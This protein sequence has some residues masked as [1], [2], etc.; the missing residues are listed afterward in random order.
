MNGSHRLSRLSTRVIS[1][2]GGPVRRRLAQYSL[3]LPTIAAWESK[4]E[5]ESDEQLAQRSRAL[6]YRIQCD[7]PLMQC[8]PE[9]FA[10]VREAARRTIGLR[11]FDTQLLGGMALVNRAIAEMETGEGKTLTAAFPL[12]LHA[13]R[14]RGALLATVN[15][16]L[17]QRDAEWMRPLYELL[18]LSVG[19]VVA[20]IPPEQRRAAYACDI[21][22]GTAREFGFDFL[23]DRLALRSRADSHTTG[24]LDESNSSASSSG[25]VVQRDPHFA[26][27][28]EADSVLIDEARTP[29]IISTL[30]GPADIE[31]TACYR[32]CA[33][34]ASRF[35]DGRHYDRNPEDRSVV[36]TPAGRELVRALDIPAELRALSMLEIYQALE[37][38]IRVNC[39][40][41]RDRHY[42]VRDG[43]ILIVDEFTGRI[44]EGRKWRGGVHQ[45]IEAKEGVSLTPEA[46]PA[47]RVTVQD[48]FL[49][50]PR[51]AGMTGTAKSSARELWSIYR[52]RVLPIPTHKPSARI[53]LPP[54]VYAT[55][56]AKWE[57]IVEEIKQM[58]DRGRP[59]LIGTRSIEASEQLSCCLT[60]AEIS[61]HVLNAKQ[62]AREAEIVAQ[63][64]QP[65]K[66]TVAT[67]MAGRGT[68][69]R[70]GQGVA[71]AGGLHVIGTEM[72]DSARIDRQLAGRC[73]RQGDPGSFRQFLALD[74][75]ILQSALDPAGGKRLAA[76]GC[77][78]DKSKKLLRHFRMAQR[79]IERRQYRERALLLRYE[80]QRK[81]MQREMGQDPYLDIPT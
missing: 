10:L 23:R 7:E 16:Y 8:V 63:A 30:A 48:F 49:R 40:Y 65:H 55:R 64:G 70:L 32:W 76:R 11:P 19:V 39:D 1:L 3:Q 21:T 62:P 29:L 35:E 28:D 79:A 72:H 47:A 43:Q 25:A 75:E 27:V 9:G 56:D 5:T 59:V 81:T 60:A 13:M 18:G 61:H 41:F 36:L 54:A 46:G 78:A 68:D 67:N 20:G 45:A 80:Q 34:V 57:A 33:A 44:S 69:I 77:Q 71:Q 42:I 4:L 6:K 14:G 66:V 51:L 53:V 50:F 15:D 24:F 52:L 74:D 38:A 73:G 17:A 37:R 2:V 58:L 12:S 22:Y 26:L 31:T